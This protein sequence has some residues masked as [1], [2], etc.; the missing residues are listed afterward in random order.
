MYNKVGKFSILVKWYG[1]LV[2]LVHFFSFEKSYYLP[3][4]DMKG[5]QLKQQ[6]LRVTQPFSGLPQPQF[7]QTPVVEERR[8]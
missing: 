7:S 1:K 3:P 4:V 2:S 6:N 5:K 8:R